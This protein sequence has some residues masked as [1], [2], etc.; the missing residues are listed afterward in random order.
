MS[1][2]PPREYRTTIL[3]IPLTI[4]WDGHRVDYCEHHTCRCARAAELA[5]MGQLHEAIEV[6]FA[7]VRCREG[8]T[9]GALPPV[10][11]DEIR[12]TLPWGHGGDDHRYYRDGQLQCGW[13]K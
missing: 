2:E 7:R 6:H 12:C 9:C 3:G 8:R 5:A 11:S 10:D 1:A 4:D 13:W